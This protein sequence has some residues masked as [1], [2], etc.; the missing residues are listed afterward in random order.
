MTNAWVNRLIGDR[1]PYA[2]ARYTFTTVKPYKANSPLLPSGL[3]GPVS[4]FSIA[5][6][7]SPLDVKKAGWSHTVRPACRLLPSSECPT[8][9]RTPL[10]KASRVSRCPMAACQ[11]PA[12]ARYL[13][14]RCAPP[15]VR[16]TASHRPRRNSAA[17][18]SKVRRNLARS[19]SPAACLPANLPRPSS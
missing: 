15:P 1:Q 16:S 13:Q 7:R 9:C 12:A 4:Y 11:R 18:F 17:V 14:T 8:V 5:E 3:P 10:E 19:R 2:A 6:K